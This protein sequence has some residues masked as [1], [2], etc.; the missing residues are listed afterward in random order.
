M[1]YK[2]IANLTC[3]LVSRGDFVRNMS[4]SGRYNVYVTRSDMPDVGVN[5][6]RKE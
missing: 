5:I 4:G 1:I 6:L 3:S 2:R